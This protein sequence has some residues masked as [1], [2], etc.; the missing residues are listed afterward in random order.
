MC[1]KSRDAGDAIIDA[2]DARANALYLAARAEYNHAL[3]NHLGWDACING[4]AQRAYKDAVQAHITEA[5][6]QGKWN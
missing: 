3:N 2:L 1:D 6:R 4:P 5:I